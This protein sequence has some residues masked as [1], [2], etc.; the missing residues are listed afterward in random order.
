MRLYLDNCCFNR[1]FDDQTQLKISLE[2]QA[3]IAV[4]HMILTGIHT[5]AWS[6]MLEYENVQNPFEIRKDSIIK[7]KEIAEV[8]VV[9]NENILVRAESLLKQGIKVKDAIHISCAVE[10][11]CDYFLTTDAGILKKHIDII[12]IRNPIEFISELEGL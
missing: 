7:W 6:Y 2:S 4:Q 9:E 12:K 8:N 3:K 10:C 1:P 5:L 11:G